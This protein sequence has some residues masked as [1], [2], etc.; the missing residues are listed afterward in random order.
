MEN[1]EGGGGR[2]KEG[3]KRHEGSVKRGGSGGGG[4]GGGCKGA[5]AR[6]GGAGGRGGGRSQRVLSQ[7]GGTNKMLTSLPGIGRNSTP[8]QNI[9][10]RGKTKVIFISTF[11]LQLP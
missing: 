1:L 4:G 7:Y 5:D 9:F 6:G 11:K 2:V 3:M 10:N 8:S